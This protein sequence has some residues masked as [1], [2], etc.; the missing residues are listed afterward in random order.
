ML[1]SYG[2][3]FS[4]WLWFIRPSPRISS[5]HHEVVPYPSPAGRPAVTSRTNSKLYQWRALP[6]WWLRA[7]RLSQLWKLREAAPCFPYEAQRIPKPRHR[8]WN[9]GRQTSSSVISLIWRRGRRRRRAAN[10]LQLISGA[11][12]AQGES[13]SERSESDAGVRCCACA[14]AFFTRPFVSASLRSTA[15]KHVV[16]FLAAGARALPAVGWSSPLLVDLSA[17]T[18]ART[19]NGR[20][21]CPSSVDGVRLS[22]LLAL[23]GRPA[24]C[25]SW[26]ASS[27]LREGDTHRCVQVYVH[28]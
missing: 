4:I 5:K 19:T 22:P 17:A 18:T 6:R 11:A 26:R 2:G 12:I 13:D 25:G 7:Q 9:E 14:R 21:V 23:A 24:T 15:K 16:D 10:H 28:L 1:V 3:A 8:H 20:L 27:S